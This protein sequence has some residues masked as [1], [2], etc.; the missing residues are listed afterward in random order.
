MCKQD[1]ALNNQQWLI[2]HKT[3]SNQ[4]KTLRGPRMQDLPGVR[5]NG[6]GW[7]K[8][9]RENERE[10]ERVDDDDEEEE[11]DFL[12]GLKVRGCLTLKK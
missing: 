1:L 12:S 2:C 6:D 9:E 5:A 4:T 7:R 3:K 8:R 10:R 11:E